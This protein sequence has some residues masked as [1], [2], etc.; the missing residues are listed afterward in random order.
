MDVTNRAAAAL[1]AVAMLN[2][3]R[4]A[5]AMNDDE[6]RGYTAAILEREFNVKPE[7]VYVSDGVVRI[8]A[9]LPESAR[10]KLEEILEQVDGVERVQI[11]DADTREFGFAWLPLHSQFRPLLADPRWPHFSAAYQYY[12]DNDLFAHVGSANLGETFALVRYNFESGGSLELALQAGVFAIFNLAGESTDLINA[13]YVAALP[14]SY[15]TGNWTF[16]ARLMHQ[17]SHLGDE[18]L[19]DNPQITRVNVSWEKYDMLASWEVNRNL[20]L[21]GGGGYIFRREPSNLAPWVFQAG[22]E[23]LSEPIDVPIDLKP[24]A[25]LDLQEHEEGG[26]VTNVSLRAGLQFGKP[27]GIGR[28]IQLLAE[29]FHG[30]SM[31]GQFYDD[32]INYLGLG[33][34]LYF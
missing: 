29:F 16:M 33:A 23:Y 1:L 9:D 10:Q 26:W 28:N 8:Q 14:L 4:P 22:A 17:S 27:L 20:R 7:A 15:A 25:A 18:F 30:N 6:I 32:R 31:N 19:L 11:S 13:D 21:Y 5:L 3:A 2:T 24:I 12:I 34:H